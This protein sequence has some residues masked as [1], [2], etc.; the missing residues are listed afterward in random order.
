[1]HRVPE[2]VKVHYCKALHRLNNTVKQ[3]FFQWFRFQRFSRLFNICFIRWQTGGI[4]TTLQQFVYP[5]LYFFIIISGS[6]QF[7]LSYNRHIRTKKA[8]VYISLP[9][10]LSPVFEEISPFGVFI[11]EY[12]FLF[13]CQLFRIISKQVENVFLIETKKEF[14]LFGRGY[15]HTKQYL[16]H[17]SYKNQYLTWLSPFMIKSFSLNFL[18][19]TLNNRVIINVRKT[20]AHKGLTC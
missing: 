19:N 11:I 10:L 2:R 3:R 12:F 14:P 6:R 15:Q 17:F 18:L 13:C 9:L 4:A 5:C 16:M 20:T 1:M 7:F 8:K